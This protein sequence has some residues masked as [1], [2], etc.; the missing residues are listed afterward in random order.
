MNVIRDF[1][2]RNE[3]I[4]RTA[5]DIK[6]IYNNASGITTFWRSKNPQVQYQHDLKLQNIAL[7]VL[8]TLFMLAT[9]WSAF[10]AVSLIIAPLAPGGIPLLAYSILG[11]I[12]GHDMVVAGMNSSRELITDTNKVIQQAPIMLAEVK[13]KIHDFM[14]NNSSILG[15]TWLAKAFG[16]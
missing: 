7:R 3:F 10:T 6:Y 11:F 12:L 15:G 2:E 13:T 9:T 4:N 16:V 5:E 1:C 14:Q 8:G